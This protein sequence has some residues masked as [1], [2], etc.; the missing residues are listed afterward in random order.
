[1]SDGKEKPKSP[2]APAAKKGSGSGDKPSDD[3]GWS[4]GGGSGAADEGWE[5]D[6]SDRMSSALSLKSPPIPLASIDMKGVAGA[7][8]D[9]KIKRIVVMTGAGI[10]VACGIPDF[11]TKGTGLYD[12]LA[13]YNLPRPESIFD[14]QYFKQNPKP[15]CIL[16]KGMVCGE[17]TRSRVPHAQA[18]TRGVAWRCVLCVGSVPR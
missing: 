3:D 7:I 18:D 5:E 17:T 2:A 4:G 9:G 15:F 6:L 1:M 8:R 12:S 13:K 14:I 16:A 11:R 10:S